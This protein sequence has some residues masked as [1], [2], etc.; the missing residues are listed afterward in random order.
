MGRQPPHLDL[1]VAVQRTGIAAFA[2]EPKVAGFRALGVDEL[3][4]V[5]LEVLLAFTDPQTRDSAVRILGVTA[6]ADDQVAI[7]FL[8]VPNRRYLVE[9]NSDLA[10][11]GWKPA[12]PIQQGTGR[13]L[14]VLVPLPKAEPARFFRVKVIP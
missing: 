12:A 9:L 14:T 6:L 11:A 2:V 7:D 1:R 5:G 8:T 3:A 10:T 4:L 13:I